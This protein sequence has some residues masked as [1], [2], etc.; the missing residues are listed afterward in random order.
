MFVKLIT[1]N[2]YT[3]QIRKEKEQKTNELLNYTVTKQNYNF[4]PNNN[5]KINNSQIR[6]N[7]KK[8]LKIREIM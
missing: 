6:I 3:K 2:N 5:K 8:L 7:C 1:N 4:N